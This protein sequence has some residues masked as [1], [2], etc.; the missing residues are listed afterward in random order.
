MQCKHPEYHVKVSLSITSA[1]KE[2][3]ELRTSGNVNHN[4]RR[5][6]AYDIRDNDREEMKRHIEEHFHTT[7]GKIYDEKVRNINPGVYASGNR[8]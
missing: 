5:A 2:T 1:N 7:P 6:Y 3:L 4:I 8:E